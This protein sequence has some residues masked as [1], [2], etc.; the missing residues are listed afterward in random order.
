MDAVIYTTLAAVLVIL[1]LCIHEAGHAVAMMK[2]GITIQKAGL[3]I[4]V[5]RLTLTLH[6][7]FLPFPVL[8][9]PLMLGAYVESAPQDSKR[10]EALPMRDKAAIY[11]AGIVAN[12]L[13]GMVL[14]MIAIL[15]TLTKTQNLMWHI[16]SLISIVGLTA[17]IWFGRHF[18]ERWIVP[19]IGVLQVIVISWI[20]LSTSV[21]DGDILGPIGLAQMT[22]SVTLVS[23]LVISGAISISIGL[24]NMLPIVPLDGGRIVS[25]MIP[26]GTPR[27]LFQI[28][29]PL[30]ILVMM[31]YAIVGDVMRFIK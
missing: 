25:G 18:F 3:G 2:R 27:R 26:A 24:T 10:I 16:L 17:A 12:L 23:S 31:G 7:G 28:A 29:S 8:L 9:S 1:S 11:G 20:I 6:P 21:S 15:I 30:L 5:P 13:F 19:V 4:P 22:Y 14:V